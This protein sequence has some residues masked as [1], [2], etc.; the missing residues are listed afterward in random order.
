MAQKIGKSKKIKIF[1]MEDLTEG[2]NV[3]KSA[4]SL[5]ATEAVKLENVEFDIEGNKL[6]TRKGLGTP[7]FTFE[8][9]ILHMWYDYEI[10]L[11]LIFLTNGNVYKYIYGDNPILIG[12]LN[13]SKDD[14]PSCCKFGGNVYIASGSHVQCYNYSTS[15]ITEITASPLCDICIERFGRLL[16]TK[17]GNDNFYYSAVGD[18]TNWTINTNDASAMKDVVVG[19]KDGGDIGGIVP[20]A[21]DILV[22]KTNGKI[23]NVASEPEDWVI[24]VKG[25]GSDFIN[26]NACVNLGTDVVYLSRVGLRSNST[27]LE[28]GNFATKEIGQKAN[29]DIKKRVDN[30][31][32]SDLRRSKQLIVSPYS[33]NTVWVYHYAI[34]AFTT[35]VFPAPIYA[36]VETPEKVFVCMDKS[37]YSLSRDNT[38]DTYNNVV[39]P[40]HQTIISLEETNTDIMSVYRSHLYIESDTAGT[41]NMAVNN[42]TWVWDWTSDL[43]IKDFKSQIRA[44]H[45]Q[46][47]F[48]T[49]NI[50][51]FRYWIAELVVNYVITSA[52]SSTAGDSASSKTSF[53]DLV[54]KK[55]AKAKSPY[56]YI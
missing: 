53:S 7:M 21:T 47:K 55:K 20:L 40:I 33:G 36:I 14:Q 41:A 35:W 5:D 16:V 45:L 27:S 28:Y 46:F 43:Q 3:A 39:S 8:V 2:I 34:S 25:F 31:F 51:V 12:V 54:A 49:D 11:C 42:T 13:G 17:T 56:G 44:T 4:N 30:P 15:A 10:N 32:L 24:T 26:K 9:T 29:P 38:S 22:Y 1:T 52:T 6:R 48:E 37:I 23:Y 18:P 19:Y 50:I